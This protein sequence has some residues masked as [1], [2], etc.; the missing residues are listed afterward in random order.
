MLAP[1]TGFIVT[2]ALEPNDVERLIFAAQYGS[3]WL[4]SQTADDTGPTDIVTIDDI[5][6]GS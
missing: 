4:A 6:S 1:R 5:F 2:F 3:I